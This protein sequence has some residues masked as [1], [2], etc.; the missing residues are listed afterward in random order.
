MSEQTIWFGNMHVGKAE[1]LG[2]EK[3]QSPKG[4]R[5]TF[6]NDGSVYHGD[7]GDGNTSGCIYPNSANCAGELCAVFSIPVIYF[8]KAGGVK[9]GFLAK[10][11]T[12]L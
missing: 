1:I 12:A 5:E 4:Y 6:G 3:P 2:N 11:S 9:S 10:V 8:K 7:C